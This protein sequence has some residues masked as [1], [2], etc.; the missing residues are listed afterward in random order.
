MKRTLFILFLALSATIQAQYSSELS[1]P[2]IMQGEDFVGYLPERIEWSVDGKS[3]YFTWNPDKDT[4]RSLYKVDVASKK[5][6][7][8]GIEEQMSS[9]EFG[10]YNKSRTKMIY[11][12][13]GDIYLYDVKTGKS[14][15]ITNTLSGEYGAEFSGNEQNIIYTSDNNLFAWNINSGTTTQLTNF[16]E[17]SERK[18]RKSATNDQ[19][20]EDQQLELINILAKRN[21]EGE[22]RKEQREALEVDRPLGIYI[23]DKSVYNIQI[24]PDMNFVTYTLRTRANA[25]RTEIPE[26]VTESGQTEHS[27][28]RPKVGSPEDSY[29]MG[30]YDI[31][32]DTS[33]ILDTKQ[34]EGIYDKPE[35]LKEY[36]GEDFEDQYKDPRPVVINGP[37]FSDD[38]KAFVDVRS[39]DSKDR[40]LLLL[41]LETGDLTTLDR[42]HD[43]AWIGG[44]GISSW[45]FYPGNLGWLN[46]ETIWFQSEET[47]YSHLY[48]MDVSSKKKK[49][50]T[51]GEFEIRDAELSNDK[52]SFYIQS[53]KVSPHVNHFYKMP[54]TGGAMTQITSKEGN[55]E[56][57]ISPDEKWLAV[58]YSYA[59]KPWEL[60]IM[61]N[62]AGA[63]MTQL[64]NSTT[65][66]FNSY[67]WRVP[68][69]VNFTADDGASVAAR[70]YKPENPTGAAVVFVHGAGYLQNVHNWWSTYYRE[71]MF[72]NYLA[73][74][75]YTVLDID[76]R[77]SDG[78]GRDWRTGIYRFMGGKDLSDQVDGAEYLVAE[79]GIDPDRLGIYGGSYGGFI[80]LMA[81]F[82]A[83]DVFQSGAA[84]RSVTDWAH[85][86]HGYTQ[87]ILNTPVE[88]SIAYRRSSPIYHAKGLKG[89]LVMLH[90]MVDSNVQFQDVVRLSQ[91]LIELGK[92]DW[93][94]AV[95]PLES[96]GFIEASSWADEYRRIY[97]LFEET[98]K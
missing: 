60:Y 14:T 83:P 19:W 37:F 68:E 66:E 98:L 50:L 62:K 28:S 31:K 61:P 47:G 90:G 33:Y 4:L 15:Q 89:K 29:E 97:E 87:N 88:D 58:R 70:L 9:P 52:K 5:I 10:D 8:V 20:L 64:T 91:R 38:S 22:L 43:E 54:V 41:D 80:T 84:L 81:M 6:E 39:L 11:G 44:P 79:H 2:Q 12:K 53:N 13:N 45:K 30:V 74:M 48:S 7:K 55:N 32:N 69:I 95:F 21:R 49:A 77:G 25:K 36:A 85:Y 18:D 65:D 73:D 46:N 3:I 56:I 51:K 57:T 16:K 96:H 71:F 86:N 35:F 94:L 76:Y 27:T 59:N 72:H 40:W 82:T 42:Q 63:T 1:I 92:K 78:Y 75:G 17:G 23:G 34:I 24:S 67:E 93:D 26:Y